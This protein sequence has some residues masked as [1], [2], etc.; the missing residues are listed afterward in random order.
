MEVEGYYLMVEAVGLCRTSWGS[1]IRSITTSIVA[2]PRTP[3]PD[4]RDI[5][6]TSRM[7]RI[8]PWQVYLGRVLSIHSQIYILLNAVYIHNISMEEL[9]LAICVVIVWVVVVTA[10]VVDVRT[11]MLWWRRSGGPRAVVIV[12]PCWRACMCAM[13]VI[14]VVIAGQGLQAPNVIV[15][16]M[17]LLGSRWALPWFAQVG[18]RCCCCCRVLLWVASSTQ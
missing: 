1:S 13:V 3:F 8:Y 12:V 11:Y 18:C 5:K 14:R 2:A 6:D 15:L 10:P 16:A 9:L 17:V 7:T 4:S